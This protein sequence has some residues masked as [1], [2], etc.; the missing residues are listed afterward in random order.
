[1]D[2]PDESKLESSQILENPKKKNIIWSVN[3][4][5]FLVFYTLEVSQD[6]TTKKLF[7]NFS[8]TL[9][10]T[11]KTFWFSFISSKSGYFSILIRLVHQLSLVGRNFKVDF[12]FPWLLKNLCMNFY[13]IKLIISTW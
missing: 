7:Q 6:E 13:E 1:M 4:K 2:V 3:L 12:R 11:S 5:G 10:K 8:K 9:P